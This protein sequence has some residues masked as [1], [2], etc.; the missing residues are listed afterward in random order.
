MSVLTRL[1]FSQKKIWQQYH[2]NDG[3]ENQQNQSRQENK[4][5]PNPRRCQIYRI[6]ISSLI[7]VTIVMSLSGCA[8]LSSRAR[9]WVTSGAGAAA[10]AAGGVTLS[11]NEESRALNALVFGLT[12][13]LLGG[14]WAM[15]TD[16]SPEHK[17][18]NNGLKAQER[19][20]DKLLDQTVR[21]FQVGPA[22]EVPAFV[23]DRLHP[24]VIE[25]F[26]EA[27]SVGE[28]GTLHEPH[29]VYRIKRPGELFA[30]PVQA[31][32]GESK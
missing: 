20:Q 28:D 18:T 13:A 23:R 16:R 29:K 21:E 25:E 15:L 12:G 7:V 30:R 24:L 14:G 27:D 2:P 8:N 26:V 17:E 19:L 9:F 5:Q 31:R 1:V 6:H 22:G 3:A 11:P 10:G 4:A 32:Q